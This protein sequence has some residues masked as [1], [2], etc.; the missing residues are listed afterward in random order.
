MKN[1]EKWKMALIAAE[2]YINSKKGS[3]S[4]T[5][6]QNKYGVRR[7]VI[8]EILK[9]K[10]IEVVN[11]QNLSRINENI[12]DNIDTEEKAYW[13]GF[14]YADGN[15]SSEGNRFEINLSAK[16]LDHMLKLK[17]FLNYDGE[18]RVEDNRGFGYEV[19]RL[20]VRNK[21]L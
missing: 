9:N 18:I 19:C 2:E 7:Q 3:I 16:D 10:G 4:L 12:F 14:I 11:Y 1:V 20:S 17:R 13:L 5:Q 21:N 15:I 8:S 6:L